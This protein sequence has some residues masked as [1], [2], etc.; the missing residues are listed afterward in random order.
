MTPPATA[1][2]RRGV[3]A[4]RIVVALTV[5]AAVVATAVDTASRTPI[6]PVNFFGFFTIQGNILLAAILLITAV[7]GRSLSLARG[8]ATSYI[9][10][11]G[12]VYN[13]LLVGLAGGVALPWA[14][15]VMHLL[16]PIY[17]LLDWILFAD[18]PPLPWRR[19][20]IVIVYP[21]VWLVVVLVRGATDGWVPYPFL[22][23]A[24]GYGTVAVY[25]VLIAVAFLLSGALIWA[26]SRVR[27]LRARGP[28]S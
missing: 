4:L 13:T 14:N 3:A 21:I 16:F 17:G 15:T 10:V 2:S 26:L 9:V 23:P 8:A 6:V 19:L 20:W 27:L 24:G 5:L 11:V 7:T 18:R 28:F 12:L 25:V 22:D 1:T